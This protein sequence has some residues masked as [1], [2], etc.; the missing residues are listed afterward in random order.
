MAKQG[1]TLLVSVLVHVC[2]LVALVVAPL[3]AFDGL[4]DIKSTLRYTDVELKMPKLPAVVPAV[5][6]TAAAVAVRSGPPLQAPEKTAP[7]RPPVPSSISIPGTEGLGEFLNRAGV[8]APD[9]GLVPPPLPTKDVPQAPVRPGG[10]IKAP[11]RTVYVRP[12]Y[13]PTALAARISGTVVIEAIIDTDGSIRD[14][15]ILRSVP[16][17][18]AAALAAVRQWRYTPTQ[19]N[20][21]PVAVI[22]TVTVTFTLSEPGG[23]RF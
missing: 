7:E 11:V 10:S 2:G 5:P 18:D 23:L 3:V 15:R 14:A 16:L 17:L 8:T 12:D 22:M 20:G 6:Q 4:P 21:V 1:R 19:L 13:P 9:P